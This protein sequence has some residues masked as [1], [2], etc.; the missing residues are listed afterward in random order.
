MCTHL[1]VNESHFADSRVPST[2]TLWKVG[3]M[4]A[5]APNVKC[6]HII[7]PERVLGVMVLKRIIFSPTGSES[8]LLNMD[9]CK[10]FR[11]YEFPENAA[12]NCQTVM[13]SRPSSPTVDNYTLAESKVFCNESA[14]TIVQRN[15]TTIYPEFVSQV[16]RSVSMNESASCS[17]VAQDTISNMFQGDTMESNG[18]DMF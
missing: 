6:P 7:M 15:V 2:V 17:P 18:E 14:D 9:D 13:Y 10:S 5:N 3:L 12:H 16:Q 11:A 4:F 8:K 1:Y